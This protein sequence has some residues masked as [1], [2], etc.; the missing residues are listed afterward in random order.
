MTAPLPL[1]FY[2]PVK[3]L[4]QKANLDYDTVI[5]STV[6]NKTIAE[7]FINSE[8]KKPLEEQR[9]EDRQNLKKQKEFFIKK[10]GDR[11]DSTSESGSG[12]G[13]DKGRVRYDLG[14]TV[15]HILSDDSKVDESTPL[16][17]SEGTTESFADGFNKDG[18]KYLR[19]KTKWVPG[20][21]DSVKS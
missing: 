20:R 4:C 6:T 2:N 7:A 16:Q 11:F 19:P 3:T 21:P 8:L 14:I 10:Y 12:N 13:E 18:I 5:A 9:F 15:E 17:N 1:R